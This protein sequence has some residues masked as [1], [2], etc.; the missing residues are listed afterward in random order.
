MYIKKYNSHIQ[1]HLKPGYLHR[2]FLGVGGVG[3]PGW[4]REKTVWGGWHIAT[5]LYGTAGL[6]IEFIVL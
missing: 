3:W 2:N 1:C 5:V 6:V 4:L